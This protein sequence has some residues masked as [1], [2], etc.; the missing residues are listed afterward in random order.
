[1]RENTDQKNSD[2]GHFLRRVGRFLTDVFC[3]I[4]YRLLLIAATGSEQLSS[5]QSLVAQP[6]SAKNYHTRSLKAF[7]PLPTKFN[8][9]R[10]ITVNEDTPFKVV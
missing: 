2:Y 8:C 7:A 9:E 5:W 10:C 3:K 6:G 1:M 4:T